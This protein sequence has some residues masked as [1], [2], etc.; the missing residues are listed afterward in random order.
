[1]SVGGRP[2][3]WPNKGETI[4]SLGLMRCIMKLIQR[5]IGFGA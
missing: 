3:R 2:E 5:A 1:M 4:G